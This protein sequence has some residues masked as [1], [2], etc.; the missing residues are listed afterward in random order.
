MCIHLG[1]SNTFSF[2]VALPY[3]MSAVGMPGCF[4]HTSFEAFGVSLHPTAPGTWQYSQV[5]PPNTNL[6]GQPFYLQGFAYAP[7]ANVANIV[8]SN[9]IKWEIGDV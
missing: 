3:E 6:V 1:T 4:I 9:G 2:P 7:G 8:T 5:I